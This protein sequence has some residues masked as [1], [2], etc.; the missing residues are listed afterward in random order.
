[1][2]FNPVAPT[3]AKSANLVATNNAGTQVFALTGNALAAPA[4][5]VPTGT[6]TVAPAVPRPTSVLSVSTTGM[7]DPDGGIR[8][9]AIRWFRAP[10]NSSVFQ[11]IPGQTGTTLPAAQ[12]ILCN[13]YKAGVTIT[14]N[15][16]HVET[17]ILSAATARVTPAIANLCILSPPATLAAVNAPVSTPLGA[18]TAPRLAPAPL[19]AGS[20]S[21]TASS[22]APL[23]V[24]ATV[25]A[26]A[27]TVAI[28]LFRLNSVVKRTSKARQRPSSVHI[29]TVYR[30]APKAK[31]YVFRLTE[32]PFRHLQPGRYLVQVRVGASRTALGPAASRQ[33]TI[34]KARSHSA[35]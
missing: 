15:T 12:V 7:N 25:P 18:A 8:S 32:K 10:A 16:G 21:V 14:D 28:S 30:K 31:R 1:M 13:A 29:A 6:P 35:R 24:S 23:S 19:A 11:L 27:S 2:T 22:S 26:G 34:R 5:R 20:V 9:V 33:L 4:N 17:E 3:G